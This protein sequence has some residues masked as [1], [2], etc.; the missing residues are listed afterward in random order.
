MSPRSCLPRMRGDRPT[1]ATRNQFLAM[2]TPH[3]RGST[4]IA[5][6]QGEK[7]KVYP[8]CAGIDPERIH[9]C[10]CGEG[11]PRMRGDR[12]RALGRSYGVLGFTP[13]AR[14]STHISFPGKV[15]RSVYPACGIDPSMSLKNL[16]I[17]FT[18]H[19]RGSTVSRLLSQ[20]RREVY[21]ACAGIDL[22]FPK[23]ISV[24]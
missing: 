7:K 18:P 19:A 15:V 10:E 16:F 5:G 6:P 23:L 3:A 14:G 24:R 1:L 9:C 17:G 20:A 11:L 2:F 12:P 22:L 4:L 8:A 13:H 21:P